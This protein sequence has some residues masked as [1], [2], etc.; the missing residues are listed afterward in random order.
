MN[1]HMLHTRYVVQGRRKLRVGLAVDW[2]REAGL[3]G[4][5]EELLWKPQ[6]AGEEISWGQQRVG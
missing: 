6:K 5:E 1:M 4:A 3:W 2:G